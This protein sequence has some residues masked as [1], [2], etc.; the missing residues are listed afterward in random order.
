MQFREQRTFQWSQATFDLILGLVGGFTS[1]IW[2]F[3]GCLVQPYEDF[4]FTS[5]LIGEVYST[6]PQ[7][8]EF[9]R[10]TPS[11]QTA[12]TTDE[13]KN[14]LFNTVIEKGNFFYPYYSYMLTYILQ[15]FCYGCVCKNTRCW[16]RRSF[17]YERY[18]KAAESLT[19]EIDILKYIQR[20][21]VAEFTAKFTFRKD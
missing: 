4:K 6:S 21:R 14:H 16:K 9:D 5:T 17:E 20:M 8:D 10:N 1:L 19:E 15:V 12:E 18:N 7:P 13:A 11:A 2:T 3:L